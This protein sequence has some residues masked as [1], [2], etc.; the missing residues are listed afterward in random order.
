MD[1]LSFCSALS[2]KISETTP[3]RSRP[4]KAT[5]L[6]GIGKVAQHLEGLTRAGARNFLLFRLLDSF[7]DEKSSSNVVLKITS[8]APPGGS[9]IELSW[10]AWDASRYVTVES[11]GKIHR[12][13]SLHCN[14]SLS[15]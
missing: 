7:C 11:A 10:P 4:S 1:E 14:S 13:F 8:G 2:G 15:I 9:A 3:C 12:S 5:C 6:P